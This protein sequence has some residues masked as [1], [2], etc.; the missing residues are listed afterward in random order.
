MTL[1]GFMGKW[2]FPEQE[3]ALREAHRVLRPGGRIALSV[4]GDLATN[5]YV[6]VVQDTLAGYFD[7]DPPRFLEIPWS[8]NDHATLRGLF[9]R[10]GFVDVELENVACVAERPSAHEVAIGFVR[11]NP[12]LHEVQERAR[13]SVDEVVDGVARALGDAYGHAPIRVPMEAIVVTAT[14]RAE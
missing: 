5:P 3:G 4:W 6:Q 13:V 9:E 8:L 14:R 7:D 12:N 2:F 11:G 10:A 1:Y